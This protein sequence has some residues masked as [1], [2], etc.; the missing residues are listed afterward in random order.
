MI[1]VTCVGSGGA[2]EKPHCELKQAISSTESGTA[3][4]QTGHPGGLSPPA[5][6]LL[7][8]VSERVFGGTLVERGK[9]SRSDQSVV[10]GVHQAHVGSDL[11]PVISL[12]PFSKRHREYSEASC[13]PNVACQ[14]SRVF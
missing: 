2:W 9:F 12:G 1:V 5:S 10:R 4:S 11:V 8:S 14:T 6:C 7:G 3:Q 13:C